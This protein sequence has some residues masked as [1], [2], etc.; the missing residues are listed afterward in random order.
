MH[1]DG[2]T[3]YLTKIVGSPLSAMYVDMQTGKIAKA[4]DTGMPPLVVSEWAIVIPTVDFSE[5][6]I[7]FPE[8]LGLKYPT[9][10]ALQWENLLSFGMAKMTSPSAWLSGA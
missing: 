4:D 10:P 5:L 9:G 1:H 7:G 8:E 3:R 6:L 2:A